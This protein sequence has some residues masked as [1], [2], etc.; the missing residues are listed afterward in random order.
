MAAPSSDPRATITP[1][2][3]TVAPSLLGLPL[4]RP[5][6]RALAMALDGILVGILANAGGVV[7]AFAAAITL[8]IA[9]RPASTTGVLRRGVTGLM[10]IT[11]ALFL[12]VVVLNVWGR[13]SRWG[14]EPD[15]PAPPFTVDE[16]LDSLGVA[17][18]TRGIA[19]PESSQAIGTA[20][21][22]DPTDGAVRDT[23]TEAAD[24]TTRSDT[25]LASVRALEQQRDRLRARNA[26]LE[27]ELE[28]QRERTGGIGGFVRGIA[29][30]L[31]VGFGWGALYFTA[32]LALWRGQTP[33]KR[34]LGL[35]VIRLDG[36]PIGWWIAFERFGG[37]A[38][39]FSIG[40]LGFAQILWDRNRQGLHDKAVETVVIR[41]LVA[42]T[43]EGGGWQPAGR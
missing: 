8:W 42:S 13:I 32:F 30:D 10:R 5:W 41:D 27:R 11:A 36:R 1:D 40:L 14:D 6:R 20:D 12:F 22:I 4:A 35:R 19:L 43:R 23:T 34:A 17:L 24:D 37:Y 18:E 33:G 28:E 21:S 26:R 3:F 29:D 39:S 31:G 25:A 16:T 15:A 38:A 7:L 9:S 2:S